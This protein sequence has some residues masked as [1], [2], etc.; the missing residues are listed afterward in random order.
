MKKIF[1]LLLSV[2]GIYLLS[3]CH[4]SKKTTETSSNPSQPTP[5]K[6]EASVKAAD[7]TPPKWRLVQ[8]GNLGTSE[9]ENNF[10]IKSQEEWE[11]VWK[12][13][14][15]RLEPI[16]AVP[17]IDFSKEWV[18]ACMMG[19]RGNGG[20]SMKITDVKATENEVRVLI[21]YNSPGAG[22]MSTD[23]MVYPFSFIAVE[24]YKQGKTLYDI[25]K[26]VADCR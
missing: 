2:A 7:V 13:T 26:V 1:I 4:S 20:H 11:K 21:T 16:P 17:Q 19:A 22:C 18:I 24:Q 5:P 15:S 14:Y 6:E 12:E 23:M 25:K 10:V 3:S 9:T 8:G